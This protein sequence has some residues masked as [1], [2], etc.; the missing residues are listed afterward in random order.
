LARPRSIS[1]SHIF[2]RSGARGQRPPGL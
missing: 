2:A 1:Q